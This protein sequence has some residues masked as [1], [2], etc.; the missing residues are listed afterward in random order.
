MRPRLQNTIF[1]LILGSFE[2]EELFWKSLPCSLLL[3]SSKDLEI[4]ANR[5]V[6]KGL[7]CIFDQIWQRNS[8]LTY[9]VYTCHK[10]V[11]RTYFVGSMHCL[12]NEEA[13]QKS[14]A[15]QGQCISS[16]TRSGGTVVRAC[17]AASALELRGSAPLGWA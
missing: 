9:R 5:L 11:A 13:S 7:R 16:C 15:G 2:F 17:L 6:Q 12:K 14:F 3:P 8:L 10:W 1:P 4:I